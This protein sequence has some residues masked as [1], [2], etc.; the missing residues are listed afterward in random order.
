MLPSGTSCLASSSPGGD[1]VGKGRAPRQNA[2][3]KTIPLPHDSEVVDFIIISQ[4]SLQIYLHSK[5]RDLRPSH[6]GE[7]AASLALRCRQTL[8]L[9]HSRGIC[10]KMLRMF[11]KS[12]GQSSNLRSVSSLLCHSVLFIPLEAFL[13]CLSEGPGTQHDIV[14]CG[15]E[16]ITY[17]HVSLVFFNYI[18]T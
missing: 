12:S 10:V 13:A 9:F 16:D 2:A 7:M 15:K 14:R 17:V 5:Y 4:F 3:L 6:S 11:F 18:L 8:Q 1:L